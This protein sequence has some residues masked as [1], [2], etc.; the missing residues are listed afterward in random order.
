[1]NYEDFKLRYNIEL[2][3]IKFIDIRYIINLALQ[4][5]KLPGEKL[6]PAEY[7]SIPLLIDVALS[8]S[9]GCSKYHQFASKKQHLNNKMYV[10]EDKW[11]QELNSRFSIHF[12]ENARR[13]CSK[14]RED[15]TTKWLQFQIVRHSL[16]NNHIVSKFIPNVDASCQFCHL[17][18]ELTSHLFYSCNKVSDFLTEVFTLISNTGL[19]FSPT[20]EQFLFGYLDKPFNDPK[21]YLVLTIKRY[22]WT[23]KFKSGSLSFVGFKSHLKSVL[24]NLKVLYELKKELANVDNDFNV[25]NNIFSIL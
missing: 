19:V 23:T 4:K 3:E 18:V 10:R 14:I 24:S 11:H 17:S 16:Q 22:I 7:P 13:L 2:E 12:W 15:N 5:M 20:R 6:L 9:K 1:M 25:W 8:T 21:N